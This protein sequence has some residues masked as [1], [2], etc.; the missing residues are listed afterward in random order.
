MPSQPVSVDD[1]IA[2]EKRLRQGGHGRHWGGRRDRGGYWGGGDGG[3]GQ[4]IPPDLDP[5]QD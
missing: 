5:D 2:T 1:L 3:R 4:F